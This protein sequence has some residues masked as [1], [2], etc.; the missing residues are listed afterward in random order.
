MILD[1]RGSG[2]SDPPDPPEPELDTIVADIAA[3]M[4]AVG[5]SRAIIVAAS[6][7]SLAGIRLAATRPE[8]VSALVLVGAAPRLS[9][10]P[11][12][13]EGRPP[14]FWDALAEWMTE[15]WGDPMMVELQAPSA[16]R[17]PAFTAWM[18]AYYRLASSPRRAIDGMRFLQVADER[19]SL[20]KITAPTLVL[21]R[22]GDGLVT[23]EQG[24]DL[25]AHIE[26]AR[27][28]ELEGDDHFVFGGDVLEL[29]REVERFA[30]GLA[31]TETL[32]PPP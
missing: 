30:A 24:R 7:A 17:D 10:A 21:H 5:S 29:A 31:Q 16:S 4:S 27:Y 25:A 11:D 32:R 9:L 22:K 19:A 20:V 18:A 26:G 12:Y 6:E 28:V 14:A 13:P 8:L 3:V 15:H 1:R 2:L 23:P